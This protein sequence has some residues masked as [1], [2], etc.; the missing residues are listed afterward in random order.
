MRRRIVFPAGL[1]AFALVSC[2]E[3]QIT[4]PR[5]QSRLLVPRPVVSA[6][7]ADGKIAFVRADTQSDI[8][9]MNPDG[10]GKT[11]ITN[12][13]N[14]DEGSPS[15][16]P[17]GTQIAFSSNR[18]EANSE[19][20]IMNADGTGV[21]RLTNNTTL[22]AS[23]AWSPTGTQIAFVSQRATNN[24][25][26]FLMNADGTNQTRLTTQSSNDRHPSWSPT[27]SKIVFYTLDYEIFSIN[28]DGTGATQLTN[29]SNQELDPA[30]SP[31]GSKIAFA[32]H[33]GSNF[34]IFV[35]NPDGTGQTSI[36][37]GGNMNSA[38]AWSPDGTRMAVVGSVPFGTP[39]EIFVMNADGTGAVNIGNTAANEY[40]D[41]PSWWGPKDGDGDGIDNVIDTAPTIPSTGFSDIPLGGKTAGVIE[42]VPANVAVAIHEAIPGG[43]RVT[44]TATGTVPPSARVVIKLTG[45][46]QLEKLVIPGTYLITDPETSV[47][48]DTESGGPAE[49]ELTLNGSLILISIAEGAS[50]TVNETTNSSG[51]LTDVTVS[52]VTGDSGDVTVNGTTVEPGDP[53]LAVAALAAK[54]SVRRGQL[55][56]TATLTL[57]SSSVID[58]G[59]EDL[60]V[61]IGEYSFVKTGG[62]TRGKSGAYT[63]DGILASAPGV[64]ISLEVKQAK[65]GGPWTV[66]A[67]ASPVS[68][69]VN[70]VAVSIQIGNVSANTQVTATLR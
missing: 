41:F 25:D 21:V 54:L 17:D 32:R 15:W 63:F 11:N 43:V 35:M 34:E 38:P 23:A 9:V 40:S 16:S 37:A 62:L 51:V 7:A 26:I 33:T 68:G 53:P 65:G 52:D 2:V 45:K 3:D 70:P 64:Q 47:T 67:A 19:I 39:L 8:W 66:K 5:I 22:D 60:T 42:S 55:S 61:T 18:D 56:L 20:Y 29:T 49:V 12:T 14:A 4:A 58:P 24:E 10:S 30:W 28:V 44:T 46:S 27:G 6:S 36:T 1:L 69:F 57:G 59:A 13:P 48:V 31:D 50:A